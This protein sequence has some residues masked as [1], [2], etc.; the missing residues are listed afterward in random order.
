MRIKV[1][2]LRGL[3]LA[4]ATKRLTSLHLRVG[5][6]TRQSSSL[7]AGRVFKQYPAAGTLVKRTKVLGPK[8]NL[9]LSR[10]P[11]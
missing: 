6:I 1:P 11:M 7:R 2:A 4:A 5:T 10:G 3:T 9:V 8:V